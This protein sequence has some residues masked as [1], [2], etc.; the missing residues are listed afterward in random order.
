MIDRVGDKVGESVA[1]LDPAK[2]ARHVA[3]HHLHPRAGSGP[4]G[5]LDELF[6]ALVQPE[7]DQP[8]FLVDFPAELSP[9]ARISRTRPGVVERFEVFAAALELANAFSEQNDPDA[10]RAAFEQQM[11]QRAGGDEEAQVLDADYLRALEYGMRRPAGVGIGID[12]LAMLVTDSRTIRDVILFPQL[13][14][15][16]GAR[17]RTTRRPRRRGDR[18]R[19]RRRP[20]RPL[21]T[22]ALDRAR[23]LRTRPAQR[24]SSRC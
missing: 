8:C 16:E 22:P 12:R 6:T 13:R 11:A 1:D 9:L 4:G 18:G 14:P 15:E 21:E 23:Y 20:P 2:L 3:A 7:L 10:Q 24:L 19:R 17:C 5:M